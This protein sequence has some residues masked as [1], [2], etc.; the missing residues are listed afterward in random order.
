MRYRRL[1]WKQVL[2]YT[3]RV[4]NI[5]GFH[6]VPIE[7]EEL[8]DMAERLEYPFFVWEGKVYETGGTVTETQLDIDVT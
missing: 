2:H 6:P 3:P 5:A 7:F 1:S 4:R 8:Q